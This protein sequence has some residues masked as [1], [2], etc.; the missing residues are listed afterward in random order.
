MTEEIKPSVKKKRRLQLNGSDDQYA[1]R[2]AANAQPPEQ[3]AQPETQKPEQVKPAQAKVETKTK[4]VPKPVEVVKAPIAKI[5]K[6]VTGKTDETAQ[7]P[8]NLRLPVGDDLTARLKTLADKHGQ[9]IE[10]ILKT[11]RGRAAER[12]NAMIQGNTKPEPVESETGGEVTRF[13]ATFTG[14]NAERLNSWFDPFQLGV[15][16][17][18]IK[19]IMAKLLQEEIAKICDTVG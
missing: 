19:P 3:Q 15:A 17:D 4:P 5:V 14:S 9:P 1:K 2:D 10:P 8:V 13:S 11:A 12:F 16:K 7:I 6:P 18:G